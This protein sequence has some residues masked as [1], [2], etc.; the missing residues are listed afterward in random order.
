[1][2]IETKHVSSSVPQHFSEE[3][4]GHVPIM[5]LVHSIIPWEGVFFGSRKINRLGR[6]SEV[7]VPYVN[8]SFRINH[9]TK[10]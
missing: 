2:F 4:K 8:L 6:E 7:N 5:S 10:N 1:M 9:R 3:V